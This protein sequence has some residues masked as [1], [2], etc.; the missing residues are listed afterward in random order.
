MTKIL[1]KPKPISYTKT[2]KREILGLRLIIKMYNL[3]LVDQ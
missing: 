3:F 2:K 1:I